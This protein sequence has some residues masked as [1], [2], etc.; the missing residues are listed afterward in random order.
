MGQ[1]NTL[2]IEGNLTKDSELRYTK[3]GQAL[4]AFVVANNTYA[5]AGKEEHVSFLDCVL[6]G[7]RAEKLAP[8]LL[9]GT[10]VVL[11]GE[12]R[13]E[14]WEHEGEKRYGYKLVVDKLSLR[15]K[16]DDTVP[17]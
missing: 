10:G 14:R 12:L 4:C 13:Q 17:F 15:R 7:V 3:D 5:G 2:V 9:K 6:W 8:Y 16:A 1:L 11:M